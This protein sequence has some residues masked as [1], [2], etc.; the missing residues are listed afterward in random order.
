[1]PVWIKDDAIGCDVSLWVEDNPNPELRGTC[2]FQHTISLTVANE[3]AQTFVQVNSFELLDVEAGIYFYDEVSESYLWWSGDDD[4][5]WSYYH[6]D[7]DEADID[8]MPVYIT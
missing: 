8:F 3:P 7:F 6:A 2:E 4:E 1:M 5:P